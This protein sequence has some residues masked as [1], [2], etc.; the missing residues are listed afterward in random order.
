MPVSAALIDLFLVVTSALLN[1]R[2]SQSQ[3]K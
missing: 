3:E 2:G 1:E